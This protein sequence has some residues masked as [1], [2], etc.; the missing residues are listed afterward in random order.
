[1]KNELNLTYKKIYKFSQKI[2]S[3]ENKVNI[4]EWMWMLS[5]LADKNFEVVFYD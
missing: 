5:K 1:M 2:S 4:L 3:H